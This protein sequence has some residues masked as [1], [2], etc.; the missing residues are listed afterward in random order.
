MKPPA[1]HNATMKPVM[2]SRRRVD[3]FIGVLLRVLVGLTLRDLM[4]TSR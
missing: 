3:A 1:P 4:I 2:T